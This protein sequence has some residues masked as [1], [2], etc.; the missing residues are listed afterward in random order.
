MA[1]LE[2]KLDVFIALFSLLTPIFAAIAPFIWLRT[3]INGKNIY[4]V[5]KWVQEFRSEI[6]WN[7]QTPWQVQIIKQGFFTEN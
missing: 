3:L 1:L 2:E 6:G 7:P 5:K 4:L